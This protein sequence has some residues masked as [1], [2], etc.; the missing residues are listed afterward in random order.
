MKQKQSQFSDWKEIGFSLETTMDGSP[1][2]RLINQFQVDSD[3]A[4]SMH[5]S[6]GAFSESLYIYG[7]IIDLGMKKLRSAVQPLRVLSLGLGL[8]YNELLV[9]AYVLKYDLQSSICMTSFEIIESLKSSFLSYCEQKQLSPEIQDTYD[10]M[11]NYYVKHFDLKKN[12]LLSLLTDLYKN[13]KWTIN[14]DFSLYNEKSGF[15]ILLYDAFSGKTNQELW[16]EDFL[17][18]KLELLSA[19]RAIFATYAC[20]ASL[21]KALRKSNYD[22]II[23][24]GFQGKRNCTQAHRGSF[25]AHESEN[26]Y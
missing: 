23:K 20:R 24:E 14:S 8:G 13:N 21:K 3:R 12:D 19:D 7:E 4:E 25:D 22:L 1:T 9:A 11:L 10:R 6:G 5:H 15:H 17:S 18:Q 16:T 26:S 2:L